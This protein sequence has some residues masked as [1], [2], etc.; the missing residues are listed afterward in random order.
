M[1]RELTPHDDGNERHEDGERYRRQQAGDDAH[2]DIGHLLQPPQEE[3]LLF[4]EGDLADDTDDADG[5]GPEDDHGRDEAQDGEAADD[6]LPPG[7]LERRPYDLGRGHADILGRHVQGLV[8]R[9]HLVGS[10]GVRLLVELDK[11]GANVLA[12]AGAVVGLGRL[13]EWQEALQLRAAPVDRVD[14]LT[15]EAEQTGAVRG[16]LLAGDP[17][18]RH[19][20]RLGIK[21]RRGLLGLGTAFLEGLEALAVGGLDELALGLFEAHGHLVALLDQLLQL[22]GV[23]RDPDIAH[24]TLKDLAQARLVK[25]GCRHR[26]EE[27]GARRDAAR[28]EGREQ[29]SL[30][31]VDVEDGLA[32]HHV[33]DEAVEEPTDQRM[34]IQAVLAR[35]ADID[36]AVR[37]YVELLLVAATRGINGEEDRPGD[38]EADKDNRDADAQESQEEVGV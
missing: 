20:A 17:A 21:G 27:H 19:A 34:G 16:P 11:D 30:A 31:Q 38:T 9:E 22:L 13:D 23:G 1:E 15:D 36:V 37:Q 4:Q 7:D 28:V 32:C 10:L 12:G 18:R 33:Q 35:A 29:E 14:L 25:V 26:G 6:A 2:D 8:V 5:D 3:N 24:R